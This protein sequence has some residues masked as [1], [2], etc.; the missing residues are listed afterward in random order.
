HQYLGL[1]S[2]DA[3]KGCEFLQQVAKEVA[4]ATA[5]QD[6]IDGL[7]WHVLMELLLVA[8]V[9]DAADLRA[10]N[11]RQQVEFVKTAGGFRERQAQALAQ[12]PLRQIHLE[13]GRQPK[14]DT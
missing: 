14:G 9:P 4:A 12:E 8:G 5:F 11:D 1:H 13:D 10:A 3:G 2:A 7:E 6:L